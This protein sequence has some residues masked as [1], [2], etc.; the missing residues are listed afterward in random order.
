MTPITRAGA[1]D[2]GA[3][4]ALLGRVSLP[5]EGVAEHF[6]HFFVARDEGALVGCVGMEH[7]GESALL[8]SLAVAPEAQRG[9]LGRE[10]TARLLAEARARGVRDVVLLTTAADFFIRHF[11]FAPAER[12]AFDAAFAAS[13]EW[14]LP[15]CSSAA[16][17]RLRLQACGC[18]YKIEGEGDGT[19]RA[20]P[21][22][23]HRQLGAQPDGRGAAPRD[24]R[25]AV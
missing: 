25:G 10:L 18:A 23:L 8:R 4:L 9:G 16:C 20:S 3:A 15:R 5:T 17:L 22:S 6:G 14:R 24:G 19:E 7:Y 2:L 13:P 11:S 21:D 12:A 1:E